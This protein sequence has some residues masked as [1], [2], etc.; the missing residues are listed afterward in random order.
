EPPNSPFRIAGIGSALYP[1]T[2][3][4]F[5]FEDARVHDPMTNGRSFGFLRELTRYDPSDYYAKWN[6]PDSTLLDLLNVRFLITDR[7]IDLRNRPRYEMLY[8][9][10]DGRIYRNHDALPR[11]FSVSKLTVAP[12]PDRLVDEVRGRGGW[13]GRAVGERRRAA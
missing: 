12:A 7:T 8:D 2:N 13:G 10:A 1:N 9:G 11:F 6:D 4:M 3:V 5:G